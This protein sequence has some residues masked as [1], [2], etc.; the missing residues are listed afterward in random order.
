MITHIFGL[1]IYI[2]LYI[3]AHT[4]PV[5]TF[6]H[7]PLRSASEP[8]LLR[9]PAREV[10]AHQPVGGVV[11]DAEVPGVVGGGARAFCGERSG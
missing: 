5:L 8:P 9:V 6:L 2:L 7:A 1:Y 3:Y 4:P 11:G 10:G